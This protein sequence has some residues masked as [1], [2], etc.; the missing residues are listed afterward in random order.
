[1]FYHQFSF[2]KKEELSVKKYKG[3]GICDVFCD[4][5]VGGHTCGH[6]NVRVGGT[7]LRSNN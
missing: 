1:M 5:E 3:E 2:I 6:Y 7:L 4:H